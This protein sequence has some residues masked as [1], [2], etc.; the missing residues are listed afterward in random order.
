VTCTACPSDAP[1][2]RDCVVVSDQPRLDGSYVER[3]LPADATRRP[4]IAPH[5]GVGTHEQVLSETLDDAGSRIKTSRCTNVRYGPEY[6]HGG[7][8]Y[9]PPGGRVHTVVIGGMPG[10]QIALIALGAALLA[11][12]AA[13]VEYRAWTAAA[14]R[15][16]Q[17]P[18]SRGPP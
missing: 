4:G 10:W 18:E 9:A 17:P 1:T 2:L 7:G 15:S 5:G 8:A 16:P 12:T 14:S 11:A 6:C 3:G 13:A